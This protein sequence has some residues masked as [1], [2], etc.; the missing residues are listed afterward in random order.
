MSL[1]MEI[2]RKG[3][4]ISF[5]QLFTPEL[6]QSFLDVLNHLN[7]P[8]SQ[9]R[10]A[11][12]YGN[13]GLT[14]VTEYGGYGTRPKVRS[15]RQP[16]PWSA[17]PGLAELRDEIS[18]ITGAIYTVCIIQCYPN[19]RVGIKPHRDKEMVPGTTIAGLSVGATRRMV[20]EPTWRAKGEEPFF[21]NLPS[22]SL[23]VLHPPTNDNW[24]HSIAT[25]GTAEPRYSLTFRN[26]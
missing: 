13:P 19:G 12:I 25:D 22:G 23:Y 24:L 9:K 6:S 20:L 11:K 15:E 10:G 7:W 18:R 8:T 5:F 16:E 26:Y 2:V 3:L 1:E 14:Y 21:F 4:R 17:V